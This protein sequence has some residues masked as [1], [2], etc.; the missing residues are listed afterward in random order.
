MLA[1]ADETPGGD[2]TATSHSEDPEME[3][4]EHFPPC[5]TATEHTSP[6]VR[7]IQATRL[8]SRT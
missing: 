2:H 3:T 1:K 4:E 7:L 8:P 5:G 6:V